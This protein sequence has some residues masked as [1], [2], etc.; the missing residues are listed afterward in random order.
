M[1]TISHTNQLDCQQ[2]DNGEV[3]LAERRSSFTH[4][5]STSDSSIIHIDNTNPSSNWELPQI[6][7]R[8]VYKLHWWNYI[9]CTHIKVSSVDISFTDSQDPVHINLIDKQ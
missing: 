7:P 1:D 6:L 2:E 8:D 9:A 3:S 5:C 4:E